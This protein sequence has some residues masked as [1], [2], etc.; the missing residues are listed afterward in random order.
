MLVIYSFIHCSMAKL[1]WGFFLSHIKIPWV[2]PRLFSEFMMSWRVCGLE[3]FSMS[4][5]HALLGAIYWRLWKKGIIGSLSG[6]QFG[7]PFEGEWDSI[8]KE[9]L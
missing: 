7:C 4:I 6:L 8:R 9:E 1:V 3:T 2:F 5:W